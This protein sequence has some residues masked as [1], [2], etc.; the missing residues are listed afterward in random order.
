[1][2]T[3][4]YT[5]YSYL[6]KTQKTIQYATHCTSNSYEAGNVDQIPVTEGTKQ[7]VVT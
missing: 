4:L 3:K 6:D 5:T 2:T 1:M 7:W